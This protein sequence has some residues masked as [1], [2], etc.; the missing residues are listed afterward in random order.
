MA[1]PE[2]L[3]RTNGKKKCGKVRFLQ[4]V[5]IFAEIRVLDVIGI[6][7]YSCYDL[8]NIKEIFII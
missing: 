3:A 6:L 7:I 2:K 1:L 4:G 8:V 5:R